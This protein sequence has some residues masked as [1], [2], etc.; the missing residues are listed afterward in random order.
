MHLT[1][2]LDVPADAH[3]AGRMLADPSYVA[4]K[5]AATGATEQHVDVTGSAAGSFTVT[6]RRSLPTDQI[7]AQMRSL[8]GNALD[9]RQAEAWEA[10]ADDGTRTGTVAL[11]I[12]GA[13]L[14]LTGTVRLEPTGPAASRLVY[15]GELKASV[16]LFAAAVEQAASGAVR[17]ALSVERGVAARW[18]AENPEP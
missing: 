1:V 7:P 3:R 18:L 13:P 10:A 12:H 5:V 2:A 8:V 15:D 16:P 6:T 11:E 9:V 17:Q 14:R 4:A